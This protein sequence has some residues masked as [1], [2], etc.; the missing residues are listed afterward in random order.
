MFHLTSQLIYYH[1]QSYQP[2]GSQHC[3]QN[4]RIL[5]LDPVQ[6]QYHYCL[7]K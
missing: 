1:L 5:N 7:Q 3:Q 2:K 6:G 4:A